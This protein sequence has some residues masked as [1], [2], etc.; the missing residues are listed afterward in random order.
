[1]E[2]I[3]NKIRENSL[4]KSFVYAVFCTVV[5]IVLLSGATIWSCVSFRNWLVPDSNEV[6]LNIT[7]IYPDGSKV[8]GIHRMTMGEKP[9]KMPQLFVTDDEEKNLDSSVP[10][11]EQIMYSVDKIENSYTELTPKRKIAYTAAG[12]IMIAFPTLYSITG[13]ILCALW[14]YQKKLARPIHILSEATEN[15]AMQNL[16]FSIAYDGNDEMG[17]LCDSFEKMRRELYQNNR[18]MWNMLE[19]RRMLQASVAHDLRNPIAIIEGYT[20]YLQIN[21]TKDNLDKEQMLSIA[22]N[23]AQSAKR[24][25]QY[26]DSIS[27]I[28][29]LEELK[30]APSENI[31]PDL[32]TE[33]TEDLTVVAKQKNIQVDIQEFVPKCK[34]QID[35]QVLYRILENIYTNATR[36]AEHVIHIRFLLEGNQLI[37]EI[38]DD[39]PGFPEKILQSKNKYIFSMDKSGG[40]MGM[41]LV[42]SNI[43]CKKH[44]GE[45]RIKNGKTGGAVVTIMIEVG[46]G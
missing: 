3:T 35:H 45:L 20:E 30:I 6:F 25:E 19:E 41:G 39:G 29:K 4:R 2:K 32:L 36:Y 44:G 22:S 1:M 46:I 37:T 42:I 13:I 18:Q 40:H 38:S 34:V 10:S 11:G 27:D 12:I 17:A 8:E 31:L 24:L 23:L 28:S 14:F 43:L 16:D 15:I 21:L 26:T 9:E 5:G 33:I 7:T